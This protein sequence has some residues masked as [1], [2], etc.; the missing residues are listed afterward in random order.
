VEIELSSG[1]HHLSTDIY[2]DLADS[3]REMI[4]RAVELPSET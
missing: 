3:T 2:S 1:D 4:E